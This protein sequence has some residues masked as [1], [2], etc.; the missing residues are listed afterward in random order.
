MI[1]AFN[2]SREDAIKVV[3][4][5]KKGHNM[6]VAR[7]IHRNDVESKKSSIERAAAAAAKEAAAAKSNR[8][9]RAVFGKPAEPIVTLRT[10]SGDDYD[11][12]QEYYLR[13]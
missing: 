3:E 10:Q 4:I 5:M 13:D 9:Y 8:F 2:M 6:N 1:A 12:M 7:N 11:D